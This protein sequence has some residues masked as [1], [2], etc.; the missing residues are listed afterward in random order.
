[1]QTWI[2][3]IGSLWCRLL[4]GLGGFGLASDACVDFNLT[5][6]GYEVIFGFIVVFGGLA[7]LHMERRL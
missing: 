5:S 4:A 2:A 7:L 1:M 6:T 3:A